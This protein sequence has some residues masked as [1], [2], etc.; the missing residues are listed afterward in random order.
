MSTYNYLEI[1]AWI[2]G[3]T[4][5]TALELWNRRQKEAA[6]ESLANIMYQDKWWMTMMEKRIQNLEEKLVEKEG[7]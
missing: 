6:I 2:I 7:A 3:L 5:L 4:G 1:S